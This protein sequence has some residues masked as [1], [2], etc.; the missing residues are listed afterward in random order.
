MKEKGQRNVTWFNF[1]YQGSD[2]YTGETG[3]YTR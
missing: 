1:S 2:I 3:N